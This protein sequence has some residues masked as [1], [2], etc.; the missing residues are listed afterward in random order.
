MCKTDTLYATLILCCGLI[1][2]VI[3]GIVVSDYR[4][5]KTYES[6]M[7]CC[8]SDYTEHTTPINAHGT[9]NAFIVPGNHTVSLYYPPIKHWLL[10]SSPLS[11][12][13]S[14]AS[15]L[16]SSKTF[17]CLVSHD[18]SE[19][20]NA[21]LAMSK[22]GG[23]GVGLAIGIFLMAAGTTALFVFMFRHCMKPKQDLVWDHEGLK[24]SH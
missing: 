14:W 3:F 24:Q 11:E 18:Y 12:V 20:I 21:Y 16:G 10:V 6:K 1:F 5:T 7:C 4:H 8:T 2:T 9:I 15:A 13:R 22:I 23:A 17:E 19:G